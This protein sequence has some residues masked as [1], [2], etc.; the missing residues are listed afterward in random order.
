[1]R[2][3][4]LSICLLAGTG[5][6][7]Q[8]PPTISCPAN[9][10]VSND[11]GK[12]SAVVNYVTPSGLDTCQN[13][14]QTF[15]YSGVIDTFIVPAGITTLHIEAWGARGGNSDYNSRTGGLG[16]HAGGDVT[17]IPGD[18]LLILVGQQGEDDAVGGGGGGTFVATIGGQPLMVGGGGGGASSDNNGVHAPVDT[19]GT[20]CSGSVINGGTGGNGGSA[21][22]PPQ[23]HG[24]GGGGGFYTDGQD[25]NTGAPNYNGG[26]GGKSFLNGGAGGAP[27][28]TDGACSRDAY[29]G[30]GGGGSTSCN[31]VGGGGGGGYSGGGGGQHTG[32]CTGTNRTGGGAGGSFNAGANRTDSAG[33]RN[34]HGI[35]KIEWFGVAVNTTQTA[36]LPSGSAFPVGTTTNT[37]VTSNGNGVDSCSFTVTVNDTNAVPTLGA[38]SQDTICTSSGTITL[39]AG[40][41]A[42]GVYSGTGVTGNMFDP[43][44]AEKGG[45]WIY[46]TDTSGCNHADSVM[47][48][49]VWCTGI[50]EGALSD[51]VKI[52]PNPG[53]GLFNVRIPQGEHFS[54]LEVFDAVGRRVW[55]ANDPANTSVV[56]IRP[57]AKGVYYLNV[58][59]NGMKQTF[60]LVKN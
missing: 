51:M 57:Q 46:Y 60:R 58:E 39:P 48:T 44:T 28:R 10:T 15:N 4:L 12:C 21:C 7:A 54:K 18:T 32:T 2:R 40:S 53:N 17:V 23:S 27:G 29:G 50:K 47:I 11:P 41:P 34:G 6:M 8:C 59:L 45:H 35:V 31:T 19:N 37:F 13:G 55:M 30:F 38:L 14:N 22:A 16:A 24:G 1:M 43:A 36:G 5:M 3:L 9:I 25:G 49:V 20:A 26:F 42:G 52:A 56:D 33:V